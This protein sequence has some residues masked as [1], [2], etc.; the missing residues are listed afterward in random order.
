MPWEDDLDRGNAYAD[1]GDHERA[2]AA[3]RDA[4][5]QGGPNL[6]LNIGNSYRELGETTKARDAFASAWAAG[7]LD[8]G[9][10]LGCL[11]ESVGD[12]TALEVYTELVASGYA[13][14]AVNG[15]GMLMDAG[16][17]EE[18]ERLLT[19][20]VDDPA[21]ADVVRAALGDLYRQSGHPEKAEPFLR[22]SAADGATGSRPQ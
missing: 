13:K 11:L 9:F 2:I 20:Q 16:R 10:N 19:E 18:A 14:A 15:A 4:E 8:A 22:A 21:L 5:R 3:F 7:D 12:E 6:G 1:R 17:Y